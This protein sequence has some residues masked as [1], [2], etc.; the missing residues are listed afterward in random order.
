M[1]LFRDGE[2]IK[3]GK[4]LS[5]VALVNGC[6]F[7]EARFDSRDIHYLASLKAED[8]R[9]AIRNLAVRM[10]GNW[11]FPNEPDIRVPYSPLNP[12]TKPLE[13][14]TVPLPARPVIRQQ[15]GTAILSD[16]AGARDDTFIGA[17]APPPKKN[18]FWKNDPL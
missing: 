16:E 2:A 12:D 4:G 3:G 11:A 7:D 5:P 9:Q 1:R 14:S 17:S 10:E 8:C 15:S 18:G 6:R 13:T